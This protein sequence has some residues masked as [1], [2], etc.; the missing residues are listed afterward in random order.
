MKYFNNIK[1]LQELKKAFI[2]WCK[3]LHPDNGGDS[4]AFK[5]MQNEYGKLYKHFEMFGN[6]SN[7]DNENADNSF[8]SSFDNSM[9][10]DIISQLAGL[11]GLIIELVGTWLWVSGE[12]FPYKDV[13]KSLKFRWSSKKRAWYFHFEPYHKRSKKNFT[14]DDIKAM[15]GSKSFKSSSKVAFKPV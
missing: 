8:D 3:K 9:F 12:T 1:D 7:M 14:L 13:L 15:Y 10:S 2:K 4:E 6:T 11:D 5:E